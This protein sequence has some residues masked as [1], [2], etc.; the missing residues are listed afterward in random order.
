MEHEQIKLI[1]ELKNRAL[2][3]ENDFKN[4]MQDESPLP[5]ILISNGSFLVTCWSPLIISDFHLESCG[6]YGKP[7]NRISQ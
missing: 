1:N 6:Y 4:F 7:T 2:W 5:N 3:L